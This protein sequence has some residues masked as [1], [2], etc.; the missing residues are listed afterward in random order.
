MKNKKECNII[1]DVLPNYIDGLTSLETNEFIEEHIKECEDCTQILENMKKEIKFDDSKKQKKVINF[2]KKYNQKMRILKFI[3]LIIVVTFI[4]AI[5]RRSFIMLELSN[6]AKESKKI[7]NYFVSYYLYDNGSVTT[8]YSY[9]KENKFLRELIYSDSYN[10]NYKI[11]EYC[12]GNNSNYYI[13]NYDS[14]KT[15]ILNSEKEGILPI[16][17]EDYCFLEKDSGIKTFIRNALMSS[18]KTVIC[19]GKECYYFS[20]IVSSSLGMGEMYVDKENGLIVRAIVNGTGVQ[21]T[22]ADFIYNFDNVS[23]ESLKEP[24]VSQYKIVSE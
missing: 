11:T 16:K 4:L 13:E 9:V 14:E 15:A 18:V 5:G 24:D 23:D 17:I 1:Q 2:I 12:N 3:L 7:D 6:K 21:S 22:I 10:G 8:I 20:N 19:N